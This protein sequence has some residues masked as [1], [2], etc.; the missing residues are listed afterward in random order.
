MDIATGT[1]ETHPSLLPLDATGL[2]AVARG[3]AGSRADDPGRPD[4]SA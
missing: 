4:P 1:A 2:P 3:D